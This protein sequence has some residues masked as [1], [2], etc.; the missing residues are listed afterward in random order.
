VNAGG[1]SY[2]SELARNTPS[3]ANVAVYA[4]VVRQRAVERRTLD[5]LD[6]LAAEITKRAQ[7]V[8]DL[9]V[10]A[11]RQLAKL[12]GQ[13]GK[14][15]GS[16]LQSVDIRDFLAREIPPRK[17]L[18]APILPEQGLA[19]AYGP[20]GLGKTHISVGIAVA[21]ASGGRFLR[22]TAPKPAGVLMV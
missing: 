15:C 5:E 12:R 9:L 17:H 14:G 22:W 16:R 13:C 21:V 19:M 18:L 1:L 2:L 4:D 8:A 11:E 3:A 7:P 6:H 20:R 10:S